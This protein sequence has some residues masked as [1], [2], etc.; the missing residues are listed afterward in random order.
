VSLSDDSISKIATIISE[1]NLKSKQYDK[2]SEKSS[3]VE[4]FRERVMK[5]YDVDKCMITGRPSQ[6]C[7][8]VHIVPKSVAGSEKKKII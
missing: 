7:I 1:K 8:V 4:T 6:E 3:F 2:I 5:Y